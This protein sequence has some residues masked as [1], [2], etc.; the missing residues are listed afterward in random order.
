M[1][2]SDCVGRKQSSWRQRARGTP[3]PANFLLDGGDKGLQIARAARGISASKSEQQAKGVHLQNVRTFGR[4]RPRQGFLQFLKDHFSRDL[5]A[6]KFGLQ[7]KP[8][9]VGKDRIFRAQ[10]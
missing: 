2:N 9:P 7:G 8:W 10:D 6:K 1:G 3:H 5:M 4:I